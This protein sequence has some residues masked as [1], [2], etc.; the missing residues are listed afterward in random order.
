ME[1]QLDLSLLKDTRLQ[2]KSKLAA[3]LE[4]Q[5]STPTTTQL[6]LQ[7]QKDFKMVDCC[8]CGKEIGQKDNRVIYTLPEHEPPRYA[9][10]S[11]HVNKYK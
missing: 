6:I 5:Y 2:R 7:L 9:H 1:T 11:C 4:M 8:V 3:Q 10:H